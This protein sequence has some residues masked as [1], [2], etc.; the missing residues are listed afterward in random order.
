MDEHDLH[1]CRVCGLYFENFFP[2]GENG[3]EPSYDICPCCGVE[4]GLGD[5]N[6]NGVLYYRKW[7]I[8]NMSSQWWS[9]L[10]SPPINWSLEQ[11]MKNIPAEFRDDPNDG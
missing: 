11:Q 1:C 2:W 10:E 4:F 8:Q 5:E 9:Q 3:Q 6:R 7:W